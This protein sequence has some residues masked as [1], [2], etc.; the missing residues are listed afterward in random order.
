M[1]PK[2]VHNDLAEIVA[3]ISLREKGEAVGFAS[4]ITKGLIQF[5]EHNAEVRRLLEI[6]AESYECDSELYS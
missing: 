5:S 2:L 6:F 4:F 3:G 1:A